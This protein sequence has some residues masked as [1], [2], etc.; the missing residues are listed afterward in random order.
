MRAQ[1]TTRKKIRT[2]RLPFAIAS[3]V[4]DKAEVFNDEDINRDQHEENEDNP[5]EEFRGQ[6]SDGPR[7]EK[8]ENESR[9]RSRQNSG[10]IDS[11]MPRV[12]LD[13]DG[14]AGAGGKLV[15][16]E[17]GR[18]RRRMSRSGWRG[19]RNESLSSRAAQTARDLTVVRRNTPKRFR[20]MRS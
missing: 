12:A 17:N 11:Y 3:R 2:N 9:H 16:A 6:K 10:P 8:R 15:G 14:G 1:T 5:T 4:P 18:D 20:D 13:G 7:A 19:D